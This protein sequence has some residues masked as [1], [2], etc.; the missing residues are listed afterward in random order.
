MTVY[1]EIL[2]T[3][4]LG[5]SRLTINTNVQ[6]IKDDIITLRAKMPTASWTIN[7][8][9]ITQVSGSE[10]IG[11]S[12]TTIN[13]NIDLLKEA[14]IEIKTTASAY[15]SGMDV[16]F[17]EIAPIGGDQCIGDSRLKLNFLFE[18]LTNTL[19]SFDSNIP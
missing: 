10:C 19:N 1:T 3:D 2:E 13:A 11:D 16:E 8:G 6:D 14:L 12:L 15:L 7:L 9:N 4:C 5:D 18:F 17:D